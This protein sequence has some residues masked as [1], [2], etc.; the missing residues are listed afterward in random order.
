MYVS[1]SQ[2]V[3]I[4]DA[5]TGVPIEGAYIVA[6]NSDILVVSDA[7]GKADISVF[8]T[9]LELVFSALGY[10]SQ[11]HTKDELEGLKYQLSLEKLS[12]EMDEVVVSATRW[13]QYGNRVPNTIANISKAEVNM[14]NPQTAADMLGISGKVFIQK[15]QQGGGSPMIRGFATNRL[16]YTVDGVRMNNAIFRGGNIQ[17][18]INIDPFSTESTEVLFGP[19]SVIYGSDAIGGVM[20]FQSLKPVFSEDK[21]VFS[22]NALVRHSTAN[23]EMTGHLD[24]KWG[25][26]KLALVSSISYWDYDH[27]KQGSHGPEDYLKPNTVDFINGVDTLIQQDDDRIQRPSAYS[28]MNLLQKL[29]FRPNDKWEFNYAFHYSETSAYG[30]FDRHNRI[31]DG[32]PRYGEWNYGPQKWMMNNINVLHESGG[33]IFDEMG[34]NLAYQRFKESRITRLFNSDLRESREEQVDAYSMNIDFRKSI[35]NNLSIFYGLEYVRNEVVSNG[36]VDELSSGMR[37]DGP[38]R[39]PQANW[40]SIA[41]YFNLDYTLSP[42][43]VLRY[44][45]RYNRFIINADFSSNLDFYPIPFDE[46]KVDNGALTGS[47]GI[48]IRASDDLILKGNLATAFRSP[49]VDDI[50]KVFDSEPGTVVVPNADVDAEY[51]YNADFAIAKIISKKLKLDMAVYY[52]LLDD[53]LVRRDFQLDGQDSINYDGVLSRV[54]AIQNISRTTVFG[55]QLGLQ[56]K[57]LRQLHFNAD[58]NLQEGR[59]RQDNG[60]WTPSRHA[61]PFF[62]TLRLSYSK[63]AVQLMLYSNFQ[64]GRAHESMALEE[65]GKTDIYALDEEGRAYAP[66]WHTINFKAAYK[67]QNGLSFNLGIENITDQRYRPYSSGISAAGRNLVVS[68]R[69]AF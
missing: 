57:L 29:S 5:M 64:A 43:S 61:A 12:F 47:I 56:Y 53:A 8:S 54:Q 65:R 68:L 44:G 60:E 11:Q 21:P 42:K 32:L 27:L 39:Y 38:D 3:S 34:I 6:E 23:N 2:T 17:N 36:F 55:V 4:S 50:G 7:Q 9:D 25:L 69:K 52:T 24:L 15:S 41:A 30:R 58:V 1:Y 16:I 45:L 59:D 67:M 28:Q 51:A 37:S 26:R 31:R 40:N 10:A 62:G 35:F 14:Q 33:G 18:V 13:K 20:A 66:A 49:N 19:E 63:E 22:G 46:I 48:S